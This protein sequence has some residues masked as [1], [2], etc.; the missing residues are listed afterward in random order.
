MCHSHLRHNDELLVPTDNHQRGQLWQVP[1]GRLEDSSSIPSD[2]F[3]LPCASQNKKYC[4][5][6][7]EPGLGWFPSVSVI[8]SHYT[9][10]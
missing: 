9:F 2:G 8:V 6:D 7:C 3:S 10:Q 4:S 5:V 1:R